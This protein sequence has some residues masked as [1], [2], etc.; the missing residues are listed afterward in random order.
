MSEPDST[1]FTENDGA[2]IV[3]SSF[4]GTEHEKAGKLFCSCNAG[5]IRV[6]VP[7]SNKT[8][9]KEVE[10]CKYIILSRGP[11]P[12]ERRAEGIE[13]LFE[14]HTDSPYALHLTAASFDLL[15]AEPPAGQEWRLALWELQEGKPVKALER[16]CHWRRVPRI[17]WL[18]PWQSG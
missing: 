16:V 1:L 2:A 15:P 4:W 12:A 9:V 10:S 13:I 17:P 14:D 6:L 5:C 8:L 7:R 18:K 11:W 3:S